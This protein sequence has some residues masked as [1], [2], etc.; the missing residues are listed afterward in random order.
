MSFIKDN[1]GGKVR[2]E[3]GWPS[4]SEWVRRCCRWLAHKG[5]GSAGAGGM[6]QRIWIWGTFMRSSQWALLLDRLMEGG[7]W[8]GDGE[9]E[10]QHSEEELGWL[11]LLSGKLWG[12]RSLWWRWEGRE[13]L[14]GETSSGAG[15]LNWRVSKTSRAECVA[16]AGWHGAERSELHINLFPSS[17][18][19]HRCTVACVTWSTFPTKWMTIN[20]QL[21]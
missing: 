3:L 17:P 16:D 18:P 1:S 14:W 11:T 20:D 5:W 9:L 6:M 15:T 12:W 7:D 8:M 19:S 2:C 4:G 21:D 10:K 13:G